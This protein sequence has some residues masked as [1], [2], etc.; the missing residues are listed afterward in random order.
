MHIVIK[1]DSEQKKYLLQKGIPAGVQISWL[2]IQ[3][4]PIPEADAYFDMTCPE[5]MIAF[6]A[7]IDKPVFVHAVITT[8]RQLPPN[9]VRLNAWNSFLE[10]PVWEI[11]AAGKNAGAEAVLQQL[12][13]KY[14]WVPD[15]PGLIA[16]RVVAMVINEAYFAWGEGVSS[17]QDIDTAMKLGTNYPYGP[18][19]WAERIGLQQVYALLSVLEQQDKRYTVAPALAQEINHPLIPIQPCP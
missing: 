17:K 15:E 18:F 2:E 5:G 3:A 16:A 1:A 8:G 13:W 14:Q 12:Q 4:Y 10:R 7:I 11:A 19:E 6:E 9:Q